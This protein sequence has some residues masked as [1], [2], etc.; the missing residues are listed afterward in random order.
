MSI[1]KRCADA[2]SDS[3]FP[4]MNTM[5]QKE[6]CKPEINVVLIGQGS[7]LNN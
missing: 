4:P 7:L 3:I 6:I 1:Y 5:N 2:D